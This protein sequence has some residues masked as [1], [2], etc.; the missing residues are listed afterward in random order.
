MDRFGFQ[1]ALKKLQKG[2]VGGNAAR[3]LLRSGSTQTRL[4]E[5]GTALNQQYGNNYLQQLAGLSGLGLQAGNLVTSAGSRS[6]GGSPST[7]GTI[8]GIVGSV[9]P[10]IPSDP[11]LK[12]DV[13][14]VGEFE[15]GLGIYLYRYLNGARKF[16]G[17]M[18]DEVANLRPWALGPKIHGYATVNY[19]AL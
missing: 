16:V 12:E 8:A 7:A 15:D 14:K 19:G 10:F 9:L 6:Q 17:V 1:P 4:L 18:A 5:E 2:V 3:G 11:R 13:E